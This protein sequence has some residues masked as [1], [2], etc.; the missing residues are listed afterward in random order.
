MKILVV[1]NVC[2]HY[3]IPLF[4]LLAKE[5][6]V[7]FLFCSK[8]DEGYRDPSLSIKLGNFDGE[9]LDGFNLLPKFRITPKLIRYLS[10][11]DYD[12]VI[13]SIV[14]RFSI[15]ST[16]VIARF[17]RRKQIIGWLGMWSHPETLIHRI[18]FPMARA[19]YR[20]F[21]A[22][23][24]YGNHSK[25]YLVNLGIQADKIFCAWNA[26]DNKSFDRDVSSEEKLD[27]RG[28][29]NLGN[30]KI[31]LYVGRFAP[32]KGLDDLMHAISIIQTQHHKSFAV[33]LIG[34]GEGEGKLREL[35]VRLGINDLKFVGFM[36]N[37]D[38]V[39]IYSIATLLVLPSITDKWGK[40][41]WGLVV[42]EAM[43]QGC[44]VVVTDAVGAGVGGL[45]IDGE[46]GFVVPERTPPAL[47][48][49]ILKILDDDTLRASMSESCYRKM[50]AWNP[51]YQ[52]KGVREA[53]EYCRKDRTDERY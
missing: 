34:K 22:V 31:V 2:S 10:T 27:L 15:I 21:D 8:G 29:M 53:L 25:Q 5:H 40:E 13:L 33:L 48:N 4:E 51:E 30:R 7:K 36:E 11:W 47:A 19:M 38:L 6:Q 16:F 12:V 17:F 35:S 52:Y 42:N 37:K 9:S 39:S 28:R 45:V 1:T 20:M 44:P 43:I 26:V 49:A 50:K 3:R 14:G 32:S 41:P 46:H 18:T 24:V 23:L